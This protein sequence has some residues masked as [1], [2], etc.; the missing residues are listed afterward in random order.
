MILLCVVC[1]V[2]DQKVYL[3]NGNERMHQTLVQDFGG[4]NYNHI[5]LEMRLPGSFVP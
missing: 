4:A 5:L 1:L 3:I 2:E